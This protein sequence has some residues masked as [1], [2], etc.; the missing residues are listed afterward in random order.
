MEE[1]KWMRIRTRQGR[2]EGIKEREEK[3][4]DK[5][6]REKWVNNGRRKIKTNE[7]EKRE[8]QEKEIWMNKDEWEGKK[9]NEWKAG[10]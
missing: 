5:N 9:L 6:R 8:K 1:R 4:G 2:E 10:K 7:T 3:K